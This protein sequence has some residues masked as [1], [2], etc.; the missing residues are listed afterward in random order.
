MSSSHSDL[1]RGT[2]DLLILKSLALDDF[3]PMGISRRIAQFKTC[4]FEAKAGS[5][6]S[7]F[8]RMEETGW[9]ISCRGESDINRGAKFYLPTSAERKQLHTESDRWERIFVAVATALR[10]T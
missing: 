3:D 5:L 9:L 4:L 10:A 6:F 7:A 1:L 8:H 2:L